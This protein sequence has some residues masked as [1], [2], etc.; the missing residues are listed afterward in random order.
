MGYIAESINQINRY[1][2]KDNIVIELIKDRLKKCNYKLYKYCSIEKD[3]YFKN[4]END[5][6]YFNSI[7]SFNDPFEC[8]LTCTNF[9][10]NYSLLQTA[11]SFPEG[12]QLV[13][14]ISS[15]TQQSINQSS[16]TNIILNQDKLA[17]DL[18]SLLNSNPNTSNINPSIEEMKIMLELSSTNNLEHGN[19]EN[20][21][22]EFSKKTKR[23]INITPFH[24]TINQIREKAPI[25][26]KNNIS[27]NYRLTC[28][29]ETPKSLLMWSHYANKHQGFVIEYNL[30]EIFDDEQKIKDFLEILIILFNVEYISELPET[31]VQLL[32]KPNDIKK[33][34]GDIL[35]LIYKKNKCWKYEKEWRSVI[36]SDSN[37][38]V[39]F[40]KASKVIVGAKASDDTIKKLQDICQKK[41]IRL[42]KSTMNLNKYS[43][44]ITKF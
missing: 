11:C 20:I 1:K 39:K 38:E 3:D 34:L 36:R 30:K 13:R 4:L 42:E 41:K 6:L 43:L 32:Q 9:F 2:K 25:M 28:F 7:E 29:S 14:S 24:N 5:I 16:N 17:R 22:K 37:K 35:E 19:F 26:F 33:S 8:A 40:I 27:S 44:K 12:K 18:V 10:V 23:K 21:L 15:L 31:P